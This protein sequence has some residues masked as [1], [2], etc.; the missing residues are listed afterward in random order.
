MVLRPGLIK[1]YCLLYLFIYLHYSLCL[2]RGP[3]IGSY[4]QHVL[5]P[6]MFRFT[7]S[8]FAAFSP[9]IGPMYVHCNCQVCPSNSANCDFKRSNV[10]GRQEL[11]RRFNR[12]N[13]PRDNFPRDDEQFPDNEISDE[14]VYS[15][16]KI[17]LV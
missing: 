10:P 12:D 9:R 2:H 11:L 15:V 8:P 14:L 5:A 3:V 17:K 1:R 7:V 4:V 6:R 16:T 13:F